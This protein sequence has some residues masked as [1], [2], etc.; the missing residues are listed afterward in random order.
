[1]ALF[2]R[3]ETSVSND[4]PTEALASKGLSSTGRPCAGDALRERREALALGLDDVATALRIKPAYLAA[5]EAG[6]LDLLP[7]PTYAFGFARAYA[8]HLGLD[9]GEVLRRFRQ[10]LRGLELKPNLSLPM[11][12]TEHSMPGGGMLLVAMILAICAYGTWYYFSTGDG[13]RP[14]RVAEVPAE[15]LPAGVDQQR[16]HAAGSRP[17]EA[18][19]SPR[20]PAPNE[21]KPA[22]TGAAVV[23]SESSSAPPAPPATPSPSPAP[24]E[25]QPAAASSPAVP[26]DMQTAALLPQPKTENSARGEAVPRVMIRATADSWVEIRSAGRFVLFTRTLKAG[27]SYA[28][29]DQP[30][31]SMRTGNAGGL[32]ITVDGNPVPSIGTAGV[33]RRNVVLD[34]QALLAGTAVRN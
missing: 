28:V 2:H 33:I 21:D 23:G 34:P 4:P 30:G 16:T 6:R 25:P 31:L 20:S 29:P 26:S 9:T 32:A 12:L 15:L 1:M 3:T 17:T 10:E 27:D 13:P 14:R 5:L 19:A 24:A 8:G 22:P 11:P 7:G 18:S